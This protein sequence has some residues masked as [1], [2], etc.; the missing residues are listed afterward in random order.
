MNALFDWIIRGSIE[1]RHLTLLG[2]LALVIAGIN[3][4]RDAHLDA[5][6]NFTQPLVIVQA[7]APGLGS[8]AVERLVTTPLEQALLGIP[9]ATRVRSTSSPGLAVIQLTF[10]ENIDIFRARQ[11]VSERVAEARS[12]L[13]TTLPAPRL[14]PITAPVGSLLK[15][16]YTPHDA[17]PDGLRALW[18]FAEWK[19]RPRLQSIEGVARVTVLGGASARVEVRPDPA[20]LVARAVSL[21]DVREALTSAQSL[22]PLGYA[23]AGSQQEPIRAAG[24]WSWDRIGEIGDTVI[25]SKDGL[26]VRV[27][28][29]AEVVAGAAPPVGA[30]LY[31]GR[32][33]ISMQVEKLPWADTPGLTRAVETALA[34]LD[35]ERPAGTVRQPPTFR[36]ADFIRTSLTALARAMLIGAVLVIVILIMF[37]RSPRLAAISLTAL[38]LSILAAI[39]VLLQR[40]VTVNGMILGGLAIAVGE[41]LD[42]AIVDVENIWRRLRENATRDAP[43][44]LLEVIQSASAEVRGAVVYASLIVI[45][46]LLPVIVLGGLTGQIFSP[47]AQ[48]YALAVAASLVVAL[49]VTPALSAV[50]LPKIA[51]GEAREPRLTQALRRAYERVLARVVRTPGRIVLAA[52]ALGVAAMVTLPFLGGG[53]IPEF[54]EG[55]LIADVT[56]W[57]GTS[58]DESIRL[59]ARIDHRLRD[60]A[61]VRHV[62]MRI[63]RASLDEDAAPVHRLEMDLVLPQ[64]RGSPLHVAS[65]IM[66]RLGE[67]PGIRF[68]VEG[69]LGERINELLSGERAPIAIKLLGSERS[70]LRRAASVLAPKLG[71]IEGIQAVRSADLVDVPTTDIQFDEARLGVAG[72]RRADVVDA[73]AAWRQG[74][75]VAD[76]HVQGGFSVPVVIAGSSSMRTSTRMHDLPVFTASS[77][78]LP[79]S[80]VIAIREGSEPPTIDHEGGRRLVTITA[81]ASGSDLSRVAADIVKLMKRTPLPPGISW[82]LAGQAAERRE[83]SGRLIVIAG[84]VLLT[85]FAFLWMAFGSMVDASVVLGGLPLGMIGGV[86][87]ALLLPEGVS[88]AGLVGFVALSGIITRHGIMLVAHKNHLIAQARGASVQEVILQAARERLL[89]ILMTAA[90]AFFALLPLAASIGAAGSELEAP[91]ALIVCGGLLSSTALNLAAVPAFYLWRERRRVRREQAG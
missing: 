79:L 1:N 50:L 10:E 80:A 19:V 16:C 58:L 48:S 86:A 41:V 61:D 17:D 46:V 85:I 35:A 76:V 37:L 13:P 20:A 75:P 8:S 74:L 90:T 3:S 78:V 26:P 2:A 51:G 28:D 73:V 22:A 49:T 45:A 36:Q 38:P 12:R 4:M 59:G 53:F 87:A 65:R 88:M 68:D 57:P 34:E 33:A 60:A 25:T 23:Q 62:A 24:L 6:P 42:D 67:I 32:P 64:H 30:A 47:L 84:V 91:M 31:D 15:F 66:D 82:A 43:R 44:P 83:A 72:V 56:A 40:G 18:Q 71:R 5:L 27:A 81:R 77:A 69:F 54:R 11:L 39:V 29:V 70:E 7:E 21:S 89:P 63:G 14:A 9:D 52:S 55:I